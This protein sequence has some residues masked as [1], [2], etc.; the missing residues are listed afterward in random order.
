VSN[1]KPCNTFHNLAC[2]TFWTLHG[3]VVGLIYFDLEFPQQ[4]LWKFLFQNGGCRRTEVR[5]KKMDSLFW[6]CH[7]YHLPGSLK[8]IWP[9]IIWVREWGLCHKMCILC[10]G[11]DFVSSRRIEWKSPRLCSAPLLPTPG[12][13][14]HQ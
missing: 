2:F 10:D 9:D 12:F 3:F 14:I 11:T 8:W 5:T 7:F 13:S 6:K 1:Q 4:D